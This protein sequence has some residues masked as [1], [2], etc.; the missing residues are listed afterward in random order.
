MLYTSPQGLPSC[1]LPSFLPLSTNTMSQV[2]SITTSSTEFEPIFRAALAA[3]KQ[4]TKKDITS[5]PLTVQ[6]RTCD[7]PSTIIAV[8]RAQVQTSDQ[9]KGVYEQSIKWLDPTVNVL[10]AFCATLSNGVELAFSPSNAMFTGIGVLLQAVKDVR[11]SQSALVDLFGLL[12]FFFKHLEANIEVRPTAAMTDIILNIMVEVLSI[13]GTV[14]KEVVQGRSEQY[15]KKL[16]GRKDVE[17]ALQ[18]LD[19]FTQEVSRMAAVES[20]KSVHGIEDNV[21]DVNTK[22]DGVDERVES[23]DLKSKGI[24]DKA[25]GDDKDGSAIQGVKEN[26]VAIQRAVGRIGEL[27][28]KDLRKWIAPP[29][30]SVNF[31]AA[32]SA[33]HEGTVAWCTKGNTLA[34]WKTSGSLLWIHGKHGSGKSILSSVIIRDIKSMSN[35]GSAFLAYFYFDFKDTTKQD[36]RALLSSLLVQLSDQSYKFCDVLFSFASRICSRSWNECRSIWSW[37][38]STSALMIRAFCRRVERSSSS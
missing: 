10:Y 27:N 35:S 29:D 5:H 37:T 32:S 2:P 33:H 16:V 24:N 6:L 38:L 4:Q 1:F 20:L 34:D 8:L 7:T 30:P 22:V 26:R 9:S 17:D 14:T 25:Q 11:A 19:K 36:T 12:E 23:V 31:D 3:Y 13:L 15:L 18:R 28:W 21:K